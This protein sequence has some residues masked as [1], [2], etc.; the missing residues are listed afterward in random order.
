M[1]VGG[2]PGGRNGH[3]GVGGH[4]GGRLGGHDHADQDQLLARVAAV[5]DVGMRV[6][7][8]LGWG[9]GG[10]HAGEEAEAEFWGGG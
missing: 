2:F 10:R 4:S 9:V 1:R 3:G 6:G 7:G 5:G 8:D